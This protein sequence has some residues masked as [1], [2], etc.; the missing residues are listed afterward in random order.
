MPEPKK[1]FTPEVRDEAVRLAQASGRSR[2]ERAA[3]LAGR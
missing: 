3:D 2:R 1:R